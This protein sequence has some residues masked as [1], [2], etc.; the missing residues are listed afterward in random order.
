[1]KVKKIR[2]KDFITK[3][4]ID[5]MLLLYLSYFK[6]IGELVP[7]LNG[8]SY[9]PQV[10]TI[11]CIIILIIINGIP[12]KSF[13]NFEC[14]ILI[15]LTFIGIYIGFSKENSNEIIIILLRSFNYIYFI[16]SIVIALQFK[17]DDFKLKSFIKKLVY[18]C[19]GSY[20]IRTMI[21]IMYSIT[22]SVIYTN[23]AC[24]NAVSMW[25]RNGRLRVNPPCLSL[26][27]VPIVIYL[28]I[29]SKRNLEKVWWIVILT[30]GI[31]YSAFVHQ[32][33][34]M[35]LY[36]IITCVLMYLLQK[37]SSKKVIIRWGVIIVA[38]LFIVN[39][40]TFNNF[41]E[42]FSMNN[43]TYGNST[44]LRLLTYNYVFK[45]LLRDPLTGTGLITNT[46]S[47]FGADLSDVG[48]F[49]SISMLGIFMILFYS[50]I[51]LRSLYISKEIRDNNYLN[52]SV[53]VTGMTIQLFLIGIN[54]DWFYPIFSFAV[55]FYVGIT[56]GIF[57]KCK[58]N[59]QI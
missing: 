17:S 9:L 10:I 27:Y 58:R 32:A 48:V 46:T 14:V 35:L 43:N 39:T 53:F 7:I 3:L 12:K 8:E 24:E 54:I 42:T 21:S 15:L 50:V 30:I 2:V 38:L 56:E 18:F 34:S 6:L 49:F 31:S 41:I 55:P 13:L 47:V 45:V 51:I 16:L 1:M 22:G 26:I 4:V 44:S 29:T 25:M 33:R 5:M 36:Q 28:I 57:L 23:I 52:E 11:T 19:L 59:L 20:I 40:S 37:E